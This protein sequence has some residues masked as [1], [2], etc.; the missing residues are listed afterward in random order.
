MRMRPTFTWL[1]MAAVLAAAPAPAHHRQKPP[2]QQFTDSGDTPLPRLPTLGRSNTGFIALDGTD[3]PVLTVA[4]YKNPTLN[5][6][7]V[8]TGDN[9]NLAMSWSGTAAAWDTD[10]PQQITGT[11]RQIMFARHGVLMQ[12]TTDPTGTSVN[13][14]LDVAGQRIAFESTADF[15]N[16]NP[17]GVRQV[18]LRDVTGQIT[19]MSSGNGTSQNPVLSV[20]KG[21]IAFESTSD[22]TT[23][24]DTGVSQIW[25]GSVTD[26]ARS[27]ITDGHVSSGKPT[28]SNDGQV[29]AFESLANLA[30]NKDT[31]GKPQ[32]FIYHVKSKTYAQITRETNGCTDPAV[33]RVKQDWRISYVCKDDTG[34][35]IA[36]FY[37]LR[38]DDRF[39]VDTLG[40]DTT[41]V[42]TELGI[43]FIVVSTTGD[44]ATKNGGKPTP[45]HQI[46]QINLFK[47]PADAFDA[48][49]A[50]RWF[51]TRGVPPIF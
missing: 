6:P 30:G 28:I 25:F 16:Q 22:P 4:P 17:M 32:I 11:G 1:G 20:Q 21:F 10:D 19:Q 43:H 24:D 26:V 13:P 42:V 45:G 51:P 3:R 49:Y 36:Y 41:R 33:Y 5:T 44:L 14:A 38:A 40:G 2:I 8:S 23:G 29:I 35:S 50:A 37:M 18:F 27:P 12:A 39:R 7:L 9:Q 31:L 47:R 48:G 15:A 34:T 46:Y